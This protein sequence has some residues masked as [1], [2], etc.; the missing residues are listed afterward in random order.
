MKRNRLKSGQHTQV[1]NMFEMGLSQTRIADSL[2]VPVGAVS[3]VIRDKYGDFEGRK[4]LPVKDMVKKYKEGST[5]QALAIEYNV[6]NKVIKNR[7]ESAGVEIKTNAEQQR[8]HFFNEEFFSTIDT[9]AKA[10]WLGFIFADGCVHGTRKDISIALS[11]SDRAHLEKFAADIEYSGPGLVSDH[12]SVFADV[13]ILSSKVS[14]RSE[15]MWNDLVSHGC[16]P[17]KSLDCGPPIGLPEKFTMDFIRGVI[18]GD[19]YISKAG[20]PSVEIV[21]SHPLLLWIAQKL[22]MDSPRPHKSV[23]RIRA[24]GKRAKEIAVSTYENST[25]Y[26]DRKRRCALN[27]A[28][29]EI[30]EKRVTTQAEIEQIVQRHNNGFAVSEIAMELDL[31]WHTVNNYLKKKGLK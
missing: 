4:L 8:K 18:D 28:D 21:G 17:N 24:S 12:K 27:I 7:L 15:K 31:G 10:Y 14:L 23:W 25:I 5:M 9:E 30:R 3:K 16:L 2:W 11:L 22:G 29:V 20:F 6:T 19:G 13:D 1:L 26:M